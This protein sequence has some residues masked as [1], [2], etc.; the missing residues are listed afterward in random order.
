MND[1]Y[2][3]RLRAA[4]DALGEARR[5]VASPDI[6]KRYTSEAYEHCYLA[7]GYSTNPDHGIILIRLMSNI[8]SAEGMIMSC[9]TCCVGYID[10]IRHELGDMINN[11]IN[12]K[13]E[14]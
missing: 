2:L 10:G 8:L 7:R 6:L 3:M 4:K 13:R 14:R 9:P 5:Y 12:K 11:E 1:A